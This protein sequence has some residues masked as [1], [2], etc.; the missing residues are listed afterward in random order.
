MSFNKSIAEKINSTVA[1]LMRKLNDVNIDILGDE[2]DVLRITQKNKDIF[3]EVDESVEVSIIS[4]VIIKHPWGNNI[5]LF[6]KDNNTTG[7]VNTTSVD[8]WDLL[9]IEIY[10]KFVG[11]YMTQPASLDVKDIIVEVL[12]DEHGNK[13]P[14]IIQLTKMFGSFRSRFMV[15]KRFEGALYRNTLTNEMQNA[16][17]NYLNAL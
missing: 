17:D 11:D 6:G 12:T 5:R 8:L 1:P 7:N 3:G 15:G 10:V 9:P 2:I 14:L 13:I 16:I 4:N